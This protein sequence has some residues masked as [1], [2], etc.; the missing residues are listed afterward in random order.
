MGSISTWQAVG[1]YEVAV[2][3]W[4]GPRP[5]LRWRSAAGRELKRPP[6]ALKDEPRVRELGALAGWIGDHAAQAL[7]TVERWMTRSLP[8][9][10]ALIRQVWPDPCWRRVLRYAVVAPCG[11]PGEVP[12]APDVRRAGV[13][14]GVAAGEDGAL[15]VTGLDGDR[16]LD[17]PLVVIPHP[18][19]LDPRGTGLL[20]AWRKLLETL[21]G[22]QGVEQLHRAVYARPDCSPAPGEWGAPHGLTVFGG[23]C[24]PSGAHFERVVN[25]FGGRIDGE[26]ARFGLG[27]G[28][29]TYRMAAGLRYQGPLAPVDLRNFSFAEC[30]AGHGVGA[31][32]A[33]PPP[34]WSE[35]IRAMAA[36]YDE[37][38]PTESARAD[39]RAAD[40]ADA[41]QSFL[42]A[43]ARYAA[44]GAPRAASP[45]P[46]PDDERRLLD[47]G[48][49]L[50]G[51]PE[52]ADEEA[53]TARRYAWPL[54]A[55]DG[56]GFVRL[57]TPR[58][59]SAQDA[60]ARALGL[61]PDAGDPVPVGRVPVRRLDFLSRVC[62]AHPEL[63]REAMGLL[64]AFQS[65]AKTALTKPGRAAN[66]LRAGLKK[67]TAA[68]PE[69][70]PY[71]LDEGARI[72]AEAGSTAMARTLYT[73]AR[74][75]EKRTGAVDEAV[76][77]DLV[78]EFTELGVVDP[79]GLARYR[80][81]L[82]ARTSPQEAHEAYRHLV[83]EWCRT[84]SGIGRSGLGNGGGSAPDGVP[85]EPG[86]ELPASFAVELAKGSARCSPPSTP[87]R[88]PPPTGSPR[89]SPSS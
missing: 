58:T 15:L 6:A 43:C 61:E 16:E 34:V 45:P 47:A 60:V 19:L 7:T 3:A 80:D 86:R 54:L 77:R 69:L 70:L 64:P 38:D 78:A 13:L 85:G 39:A 83:L 27:H 37:R 32:D 67:V 26:T 8:V 40:S 73:Q 14:T 11:G 46:T 25:R 56:D 68:H 55:E 36:L 1:G 59:V 66:Q 33:V 79:T 18:A 87:P 88:A 53:L 31:Y 42:V 62:G 57:L 30:P 50:P 9:P 17:A 89:S 24:F 84:R 10:A 44:E 35:G 71:A 48:A 22:E 12:G 28:G 4:S 76:L 49:V 2:D 65:C 23:A 41:Y 52:G 5:V 63:V 75:A 20:A 82:A 81:D 74:G 51:A 21:G 29:R 72:I